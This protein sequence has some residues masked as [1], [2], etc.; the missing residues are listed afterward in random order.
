[1]IIMETA[2][3]CLRL[4]VGRV[5][6]TCPSA[7]PDHGHLEKATYQA[8]LRREAGD[9]L[10][11]RGAGLNGT[12]LSYSVT[13]PHYISTSN[14]QQGMSNSQRREKE[15]MASLLAFYSHAS[16]TSSLDVPCWL[17]GVQFPC[18]TPLN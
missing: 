10:S 9:L 18:E 7:S 4:P 11:K 14:S 12:S 13:A 8:G 15:R 16:L 1:M 5:F 3:C 6:L 17:L 2:T